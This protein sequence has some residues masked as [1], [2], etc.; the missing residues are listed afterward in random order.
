MVTPVAKWLRQDRNSGSVGGSFR[1][2][3]P[4]RRALPV[5]VL[6]LGHD[7]DV[8]GMDDVGNGPAVGVVLG[9]VGLDE[10]R[11]LAGQARSNRGYLGVEAGNLVASGV[12]ALIQL[13]T[14]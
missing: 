10:V 11:N 14:S 7:A 5:C 2:P 12:L 8:I 6:A 4:F 9:K 1:I 3:E 13:V